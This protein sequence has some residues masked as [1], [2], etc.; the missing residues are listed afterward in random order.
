MTTIEETVV[1]YTDNRMKENCTVIFVTLTGGLGNQMFQYA[2]AYYLSKKYDEPIYI[3]LAEMGKRELEVRNL[4]LQHLNIIEPF[5]LHESKQDF[6][7]CYFKNYRK[8]RIRMLKVYKL[9]NGQIWEKMCTRGIY[10]CPDVY[11][12]YPYVETKCRIKYVEGIFLAYDYV[13]ECPE[14]KQLYQVCTVA[15]DANKKILEVIKETNS[16]CVHIRRGD[17]SAYPNLQICSEKYYRDAIERMNAMEPD[18]KFFV[19]SNNHNEIEWIKSN[20]LFLK[21]YDVVYIDLN[22]PD[23]EDFR[24]MYSCKHFIVSNSTFSWW[25][26]YLGEDKGKIVIAPDVWHKERSNSENVYMP[27]WIRI[28][29][30]EGGLQ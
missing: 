17:Y 30:D 11:G 27:D 21:T 25:A 20:Y 12:Y 8:I 6:L 24:L 22:N 5:Q 16:V 29:I 10:Y 26:Q 7:N 13:K 1:Q 28:P 23:Y 14:L 15:S 18:A 9:N 19:Y 2:Y 3:N 4:A